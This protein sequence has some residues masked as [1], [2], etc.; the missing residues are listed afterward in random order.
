[1]ETIQKTN[2]NMNIE[3]HQLPDDVKLWLQHKEFVLSCLDPTPQSEE[4]WKAYTVAHPEAREA[5]D[6]ARRL[7]QSVRLN[8]VERTPGESSALWR[9]IEY[10]MQRYETRHV[11]RRRIRPLLYYAAACMVAAC[12][13]AIGLPY[14]LHSPDEPSHRLQAELPLLADSAY[15]EVT[16]IKADKETVQYA[17]NALI[18]CPDT[19]TVAVAGET[20]QPSAT[21]H[22]LV[23]PYGRRSSL[24]LSDGSRVWLN[25]GS[26]L[27]FPSAFAPGERRIRVEGEIYIEVAKDARRPFYVETSRMTVNVL[28]TKFN[29]SAYADDDTQSVVLVEG[30]V[31]VD[32]ASH[33]PV[34]LVPDEMFSLSASLARVTSVRAADY[35]SWKDGFLRM[36]GETL[37]E[38]C[39]RLSRYYNIPISCSP[40]CSQRQTAGK[41]LLMDDVY[42]VL[43]TFTMLYGIRY[44]TVENHIYIE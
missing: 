38:I 37:E 18:D 22:T 41:L 14:L 11:R 32:A 33:S 29:V 30:S 3:P 16:L 15:R 21:T 26:V 8:E 17:N 44:R 20:H 7:L 42:Q 9:R 39:V 5:M 1:M 4:R 10:D 19:A 28:G 25:S 23:V 27:H 24:L 31:N 34:K 12:M 13:L 35:I 43:K 6:E 2:M 36:Q 40:H